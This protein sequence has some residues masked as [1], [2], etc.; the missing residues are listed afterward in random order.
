[1]NKKKRIVLASTS[2]R[3]KEILE[4]LGLDF[5]IAHSNVEEKVDKY[6]SF[7]ENVERIALDKAL[8]VSEQLKD[9]DVLIIAAHTMLIQETLIGMPTT[10]QEAY[11]I[12]KRLSGKVHEI[13]TGVCVF[14]TLENRGMFTHKKTKIRFVNLKDD[15]IRKYINYGDTWRKAGAYSITGKGA[16]LVEDIEGC[17]TNAMGLP[18]SLLGEMLVEF[19]IKVI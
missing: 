1:M 19:D 4:N 14:D 13:I 10:E 3:R 9:D 16:L 6:L 5:D 7:E 8:D 17:Y 18:V 15:F 12:L 11:D 2:T